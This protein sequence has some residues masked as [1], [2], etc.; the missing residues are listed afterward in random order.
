MRSRSAYSNVSV[1][2]LEAALLLL[3]NADAVFCFVDC[4]RHCASRFARGWPFETLLD[5]RVVQVA[6]WKLST[7]GK[8]G[9]S[10][11]RHTYNPLC[12]R[13]KYTFDAGRR[14]VASWGGGST[15]GNRLM[16]A[17]FADATGLRCPSNA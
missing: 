11:T 10:S 8:T 3:L 17:H 1:I 14:V 12:G 15:Y 2:H 5:W 16:E 7:E 9:N 4:Q 13:Y 6:A